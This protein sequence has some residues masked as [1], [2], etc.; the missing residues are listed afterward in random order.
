MN[1]YKYLVSSPEV[2]RLERKDFMTK[3]VWNVIGSVIG[4]ACVYYSIIVWLG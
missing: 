3:A 1:D 2:K 4:G